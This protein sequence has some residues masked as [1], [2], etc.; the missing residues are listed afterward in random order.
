MPS[1]SVLLAGATG[2]LG[3]RIAHHLLEAADV[4]LRLLVRPDALSEPAKRSVLDPLVE[5]GAVLVEGDVT[6]HASLDRAT[7][8]VDVVVS[9]LQGG[10]EV[11]VDGQV[12][13]AG[14]ASANGVRR[15]LPSDFALDLFKS[16]PGEHLPFDLRREADEA[17]AQLG[18]QHIHVLNGS[19]L[20]MLAM[21]G[22]IVDFDDDAGVASFW[23]S[24]EERFDA[25]TIEDT[26]RYAARVALDPAVPSGK[27]AV[28]AQQL[29]F[30]DIVAIVE[31]T[32]GRR[33]ARRS[34][35]TADDLRAW[36]AGQRAA[37]DEMAATMGTYQLYMLTGQT[38]LDDLQNDRY[39]DIEPRTLE[40]QLSTGV[41]A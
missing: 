5:R 18:M 29:S 30:G 21:P 17:I 35:G 25:T 13:L 23:G 32:S 31:R 22:A 38:A 39:P 9:A 11:L 4:D 19:F 40:Q 1:H 37:A 36:I 7:R 33:Y 28:A 3:A 15:I 10:R 34:R 2:M 16:P 27:F 41:D 26:A 14:A 6:D 12:A 8:H 24:G 20:D